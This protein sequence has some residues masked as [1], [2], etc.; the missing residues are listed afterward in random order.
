M[1]P[2]YHII[3]VGPPGGGESFCSR[4]LFFDKDPVL[5]FDVYCYSVDE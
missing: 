1:K 4:G 3:S 2:K 5:G